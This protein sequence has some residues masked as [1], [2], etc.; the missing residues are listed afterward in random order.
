MAGKTLPE[1]ME[2]V[3]TTDCH[4]DKPLQPGSR[5][6]LDVRHLTKRFPIRGGWL[7]RTVANAHAVEDVTFRLLENET[8]SLVGE[9]GSGKS[10]TAH[11]I[12]RLERPD[13]GE[14]T[15]DGQDLLALSDEDMRLAAATCR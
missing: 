5:V 2:T 13:G 14:I 4:I 11:C 15:F 9:S 8:L 1:P 6:L 10:V 7:G 3:A 12:L